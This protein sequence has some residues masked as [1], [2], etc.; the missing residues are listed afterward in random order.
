MESNFESKNDIIEI[1][2][3]ILKQDYLPTSILVNDEL[4]A[5]HLFGKP[6]EFLCFQ[7]GIITNQVARLLDER[8]MPVVT[9]LFYRLKKERQTLR[10]ADIDAGPEHPNHVVQI[11]G[12]PTE[13]I[14]D[15]YNYLLVFNMVERIPQETSELPAESDL[16][17]DYVN[18]LVSHNRLLERELAATRENLQSTIEEL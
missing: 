5:L 15:N 4:H 13:V 18:N 16:E 6:N 10:A 14:K 9:T 2:L 7:E 3:N 1:A 17:N 8:L 12:I 11:T